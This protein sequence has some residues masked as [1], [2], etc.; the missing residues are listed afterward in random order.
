MKLGRAGPMWGE[1]GWRRW[2][3]WVKVEQGG[4]GRS[5]RHVEQQLVNQEH[6]RSVFLIRRRGK[7]A[8]RSG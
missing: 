7:V 3:S 5:C 1:M 6:T 2:G 8:G 4:L